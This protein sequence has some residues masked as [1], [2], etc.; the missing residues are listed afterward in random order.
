MVGMQCKVVGVRVQECSK[1]CYWWGLDRSMDDS[2]DIEVWDYVSI[3]TRRR[4]WCP[5]G[6]TK[7]NEWHTIK[8]R[9]CCDTGG[10]LRRYIAPPEL[11]RPHPLH[12]LP[13]SWDLNPSARPRQRGWTHVLYSALPVHTAL[14]LPL[15]PNQSFIISAFKA[16]AS[17]CGITG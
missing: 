16:V 11:A 6:T 9:G 13:V 15:R 8:L 12:L 7:T 4:A 5:V 10:L 17:C 2:C 14:G 3:A 1:Q